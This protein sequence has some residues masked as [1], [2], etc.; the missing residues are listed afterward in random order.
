[1]RQKTAE[2]NAVLDLI[3]AIHEVMP[4]RLMEARMLIQK[5]QDDKEP[6]AEI[7]PALVR[8]MWDRLPV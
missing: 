2:E 8:F 7:W 6:W 4:S 1:M 5:M 3:N